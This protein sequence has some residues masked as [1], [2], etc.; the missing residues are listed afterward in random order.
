MRLW[1]R[2]A[3]G[4]LY[5]HRIIMSIGATP[6]ALA[7]SGNARLV[8]E[9]LSDRLAARLALHIES[10]GLKPGDRLPTEAQL[11][12]THGVSRTV[13]REAV[14]QLQSRGLVR[15]RQGA[16]VFVTDPQRMPE[17][18]RSVLESLDAVLQTVEVRRVLEGEMAA[19]AAQRATRTQLRSLKGALVAI[20]HA[21]ADGRDG[22]EEDLAFHRAIGEATG[23]P[24][25][26]SLLGFLERY[27]REAMRVTRGNESRRDDFMRQVQ[28][29]HHAIVEAIASGNPAAARRAAIDHLLRAEWRLR[30]GGVLPRLPRRPPGTPTTRNLRR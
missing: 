15:S 6:P 29:E 26:R 19:L 20:D 13:V 7:A 17:F 8:A 21:T 11:A 12:L 30:E 16:G 3:Q 22:L 27:L 2:K 10:A 25:F 1:S 28:T 24:K 4:N 14:H 18:D 9:R 5:D 23:N